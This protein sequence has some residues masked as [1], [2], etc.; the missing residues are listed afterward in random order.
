MNF[1][2]RK[3]LQFAGAAARSC[4]LARRVTSRPF[5]IY[6]RSRLLEADIDQLNSGELVKDIVGSAREAR[7][8]LV[9][10]ISDL[11]SRIIIPLVGSG[12]P[13]LVIGWHA[14]RK[15]SVGRGSS[16]PRGRCLPSRTDQPDR[17][18]QR[19]LHFPRATK[20]R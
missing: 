5:I 17:T 19:R 7:D 6:R 2:R 20:W 10:A 4:V 18:R 8:S 16:T 12:L 1:P 14:S 11:D 15:P 9:D 13:R 3:F